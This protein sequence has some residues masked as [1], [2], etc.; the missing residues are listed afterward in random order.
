MGQQFEGCEEVASKERSLGT[1]EQVTLTC[2][3]LAEWW[4]GNQ[5]AEYQER[6]GDDKVGTLE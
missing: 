6:M 3:V 1:K 2:A 5:S 4:F